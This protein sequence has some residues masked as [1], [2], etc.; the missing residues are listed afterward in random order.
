MTVTARSGVRCPSRRRR[1]ATLSPSRR[2]KGEEEVIV[3]LSGVDHVDDV[4]VGERSEKVTLPSKAQEEDRVVGLDRELERHPSARV[5]VRRDVEGAHAAL[6]EQLFAAV[7]SAD[8]LAGVGAVG[9]LRA[10][11]GRVDVAP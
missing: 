7:P 6:V 1:S 3:V 4:I 5:D 9:H 2:S 11:G 8:D 10:P